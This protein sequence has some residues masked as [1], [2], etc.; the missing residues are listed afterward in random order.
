M[1]EERRLARLAGA[2]LLLVSAVVVV[3]AAIRLGQV[4][5]E[6][7]S[8]SS[9]L[10]LRGVHRVSAS[11]DA[12][13][14]FA[15]SWF[16]WRA[17]AT[18]SSL[19]RAALIA[20]ALTLGLSALGV[21]GGKEPGPHIALGNL[22]GGLALAVSLAWV[23]GLLQ[24]APQGAAPARLARAA[25]ALAAAQCALGGWIALLATELWSWPLAIHVLLGV[26]LALGAL[27]IGAALGARG[28]RRAALLVLFPALAAPAAGVLTALFDAP[29]G[30][31]LAHAAAAAALLIALAYTRARFA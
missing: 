16:A 10:A 28:E 3:S 8:A 7:L 19:A 21:V 26:L 29:F 15:L 30:I 1:A 11:L 17:R 14:V 27:R 20:L 18:R 9:L 31:A 13:A 23:L 22:L 6:P 2:A 4:A 25:L 24:R 12:I 5:R